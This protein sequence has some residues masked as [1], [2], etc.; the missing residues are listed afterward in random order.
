VSTH[1]NVSKHDCP[2]SLKEQTLFTKNISAT[3]EHP[4]QQ[5]QQQPHFTL[6][7]GVHVDISAARDAGKRLRLRT[8]RRYEMCSLLDDT[9]NRLSPSHGTVFRVDIRDNK[10]LGDRLSG[11]TLRGNRGNPDRHLLCTNQYLLAHT[12][13]PCDHPNVLRSLLEHTCKTL[14]ITDAR[15]TSEGYCPVASWKA[16]HAPFDLVAVEKAFA[17]NIARKEI[18]MRRRANRLYFRTKQNTV[19]RVHSNGLIEAVASTLEVDARGELRTVTVK[20]IVHKVLSV[21]QRHG[22]VSLE[23]LVPPDSD[24]VL[25]KRAPADAPADT[26]DESSAK[27]RH[28]NADFDITAWA[29]DCNGF[30]TTLKCPKLKSDEATMILTIQADEPL[31]M[32]M[33]RIPFTPKQKVTGSAQQS[34]GKWFKSVRSHGRVET[35][36][37]VGSCMFG[38]MS[39]T[40]AKVT[41]SVQPA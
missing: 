34:T 37:T 1:T 8:E 20:E 22:L 16:K 13:N 10:T 25:G 4:Q 26:L 11:T 23:S 29:S 35:I 28:I 36:L 24:N 39:P 40:E 3:M 33:R 38:I 18:D 5:P 30:R 15:M 14:D 31:A 9:F 17:E 27:R 6:C 2:I 32:S 19:V 12:T 21:L 7:G 41:A